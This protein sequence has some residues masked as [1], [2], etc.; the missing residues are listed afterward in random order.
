MFHV[1]VT[2]FVLFFSI[3]ILGCLWIAIGHLYD[4][5]SLMIPWIERFDYHEE[6]TL[7]N[8]G[9]KFYQLGQ[10]GKIYWTAVYFIVTTITTT[11]YGDI[12]G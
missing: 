10:N 6:S 9:M 1:L 4:P 7:T 12:S 3:H 8:P 11:G 5:E 2:I